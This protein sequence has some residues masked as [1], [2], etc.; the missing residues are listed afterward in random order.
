MDK[1]EHELKTRKYFPFAAGFFATLFLVLAA[2]VIYSPASV[3]G[4]DLFV[5]GLV[6]PLQ[7]IQW[8]RVALVVS[9]FGSTTGIVVGLVVVTIVFCH[10]PDIIT[11]VW[12]ALLGS[13]ISGAYIKDWVHR[14]RP[15]TLSWLQPITNSFSFPSGHTLASTVFY[16]FLAL[17]LYVHAPTKLR[18]AL[19]IIVP[20]IF[21][22]FIALSRI[23]LNYHYASDVL[24]GFLLG[25]FWLTFSL[26]FPLYY[27][28]YHRDTGEFVVHSEPIIR[29][30]L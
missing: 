26:S 21:I 6:L 29:P 24:G 4:L 23:V 5:H 8:S 16:G 1:I 18:K 25:G 15:D 9:F 30:V 13:T 7:T 22:V 27:E 20:A 11:R 19:A 12:I 2:V 3:A 28:L 10:R 17:L 14:A